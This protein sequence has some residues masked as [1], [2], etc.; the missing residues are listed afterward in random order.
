MTLLEFIILGS[1]TWRLSSLLASKETGP[2]DVFKRIREKA[3]ITHDIDGNISIVPHRFFAEL[4]SCVWCASIWV[5]AFWGCFFAIAPQIC[6]IAATIFAL[7][8]IAILIDRLS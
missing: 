2:F 3:G 8:T 1:A 7:S 4:L 6:I 5:G